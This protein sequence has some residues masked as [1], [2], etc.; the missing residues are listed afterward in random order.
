MAIVFTQTDEVASCP[1]MTACAPTDTTVSSQASDFAMRPGGTPGTVA[2]S[3]DVPAGSS[4][5]GVFFQSDDVGQTD[6]PSGQWTVNLNVS[7]AQNNTAWD[8]VWICR[9]DSACGTV[10]SVGSETTS[11]DISAG[12][13]FSK[14]VTGAATT[15]TTTDAVY[16][17]CRFTNSHS[18]TA[19][20]V[21]VTP[22][23]TVDSPIPEPE[24]VTVTTDAATDIT[25]TTATL[26]GTLSELSGASSADV[27][28]EW[29]ETGATTWNTTP[30]QTL[31]ATGTFSEPL[32]AL[33]ASTGYEYRAQ[34]TTTNES[35]TG[36]TQTFTTSDPPTTIAGTVEDNGT[37]ISGATVT[38]IDS[39]TDSV[40]TELTT[41]ANGAF[42]YETYATGPFHVATQYDSGTAQ[43]NALS[44]HSVQ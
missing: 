37:L 28:F 24:V 42:S 4:R 33:T 27:W 29:R 22:N 12:G 18:M 20:T 32:T 41:D 26:N 2:E 19:R 34:A 36:T 25:D 5:Y 31:T 30:I 6:W 38:I 17:V 35:S 1:I 11:T 13:V 7:S 3:F 43:Y 15:G 44:Y 14:P 40:L 21:G 39:S 9:V 23:Q 16:V 8:G 10:A